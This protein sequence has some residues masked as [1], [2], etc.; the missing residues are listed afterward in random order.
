MHIHMDPY[1]QM[2]TCRYASDEACTN[3]HTK[4]HTRTHTRMHIHMHK[5]TCTFAY[6]QTLTDTSK[7]GM[8]TYVTY[9]YKL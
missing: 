7:H 3:V 2:H 1:I 8:C 4:T 6:T 9:T 5:H